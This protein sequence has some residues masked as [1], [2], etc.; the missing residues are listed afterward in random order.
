MRIELHTNLR[1]KL[2]KRA[3]IKVFISP[4]KIFPPNCCLCLLMTINS[5]MRP[6]TKLKILSR[7]T[8][9]LTLTLICTQNWSKN[10]IPWNHF[11]S[12][13][14]AKTHCCA[15]IATHYTSEIHEVF[16]LHI[17]EDFFKVL[18]CHMTAPIIV[19]LERAVSHI[20]VTH[21][22]T[23]QHANQSMTLVATICQWCQL[24]LAKYHC[25]ILLIGAS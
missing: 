12:S 7:R 23:Y 4:K 25:A 1:T 21:P 20:K 9:I 22:F 18:L 15:Q 2:S 3:N 5:F 11:N 24:I 10:N 17:Q 13:L 16:L 6:S 14:L 19:T 8:H